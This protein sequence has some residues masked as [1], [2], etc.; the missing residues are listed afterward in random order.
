MH[1][2]SQF[3]DRD[4]SAVI[5]GIAELDERKKLLDLQRDAQIKELVLSLSHREKDPEKLLSVISRIKP[6]MSCPFENVQERI[7]ACRQ[8]LNFFPSLSSHKA[9]FVQHTPQGEDAI[10]IL[11]NN[12]I[13]AVFDELSV[14]RAFSPICFS[15][16]D[17]ICE[18]ISSGNCA[19]G[20]LPIESSEN[21]KLLRFYNL[22]DRHDLKI[23]AVCDISYSDDSATTRYA[24]VSKSIM[25]PKSC[26]EDP[27]YFE[28]AVNLESPQSLNE[29]L[30]AASFCSMELHRID[31]VPIA[32]KEKEFSFCPVFKIE[33]SDIDTF[34]LYMYLDF[35]QYTP[36]GIYPKL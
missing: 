33:K 7:F 8:I 29:I 14:K 4:I 32:Y 34:L 24:L 3:E 11:D 18:N 9:D 27:D 1:R 30:C 36:I 12:Y 25:C 17:E 16:F 26:L 28:F 5:Q 35:P 6:D 31:S 20:I 22:I 19:Y 21:G 13:K 10:G 15:S 23:N 2:Y